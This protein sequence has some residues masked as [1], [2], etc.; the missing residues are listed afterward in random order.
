MQAELEVKKPVKAKTF[1]ETTIRPALIRLVRPQRQSVWDMELDD[2]LDDRGGALSEAAGAIGG[3]GAQVLRVIMLGLIQA[4]VILL[5]ML[6]LAQ[7]VLGSPEGLPG[8]VG[9]QL[10][11]VCAGG[12]SCDLHILLASYAFGVIM[13]INIIALIIYGM[14]S[15][16]GYF[17]QPDPND[18]PLAVAVVDERLKTL[19]HELIAAGVLPK[20]VEPPDDL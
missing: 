13:V 9:R 8:L 10:A 2:D 19:H 20:P 3:L 15:G 16:L 17:D 18:T 11:Q 5:P 7:M 12:G 6:Y 14:L 1:Y 4:M